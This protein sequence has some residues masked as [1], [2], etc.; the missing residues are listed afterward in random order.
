MRYLSYFHGIDPA[1]ALV[2]DGRVVAYVEEERLSRVRHAPAQFPLRSINACLDLGKVRLED[3]DAIVYGSDAPRHASGDLA[4]L[5]EEMNARY[6]P[7]PGSRRCQQRSLARLSPAALRRTLESNLVHHAG[8]ALGDIPR[9]DFHPHHRSHAAA[10]FLCSPFDEAL[11]LTIDG[12]GDG[13]CTT[14]WHGRGA[15]LTPLHRIG[16]PHSLG[17]FY[18]AITEYLGFEAHDGEY[19][20]MGLA[21]YGR[22]NRAL[23]AKLATIV[24]PGSLGFDYEVD[25]AFTHHGVHTYSEYFTDRLPALIGLP[26]RLGPHKLEPLHEDLAFEAQRVLEET[27]IRLVAHF[28]R[29]TGLRTLCLLYTS[30]AAD[31]RS[32]VDLGG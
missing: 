13:D 9:L 5:Y 30:D 3:I 11:V 31:E 25:P 24:R 8:V 15:E 19:K 29:V 20:V 2:D 32:S 1:A 12:A 7:D 22:E 6:P 27:V 4:Q 21:A 28:Q 16:V 18:A 14:I 23:R 26:P 17:W 10:A